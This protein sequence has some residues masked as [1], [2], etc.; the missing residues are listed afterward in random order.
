[1]PESRAGQVIAHFRVVEPIGSGGMGVVYRAVDEE[2]GREVAL[3]LLAPWAM[4]EPRRRKRFLREARAAAAIHHPR[5]ATVFE[6]GE[7]EASGEVYLA[8]ELVEGQSLRARLR[9]GPL[10]L[11]AARDLAVEIGEALSV[12]H[13][14]GIVHRDLKP[15]NVML[16]TSGV[17]VLDFG[18]AKFAEAAPDTADGVPL[19]RE[20]Q[21][22]GT[23]GY[24]SPEQAVGA[25]VDQRADLFALGAM[26]YEMISGIRPF[27]GRSDVEVLTRTLRDDPEPL[28]EVAPG[29]PPVLANLVERCLAKEPAERPSDATVL[30]EQLKA[31]DIESVVV[32]VARGA[33]AHPSTRE[34]AKTRPAA[35]VTPQT[36]PG[37]PEVAPAGATV[38]S[39][40]PVAT[41]EPATV[42]RSPEPEAP[43]GDRKVWRL[44]AAVA[45][46]GAV[47]LVAWRLGASGEDPP[48]EPAMLE[49]AEVIA[50]A[51]E[52]PRELARGIDLLAAAELSAAERALQAAAD[53]APE[54]PARGRVAVYQTMVQFA[55]G[56]YAAAVERVQTA[57]E[58]L[59]ES[60][61]P[62]AELTRY[63]RL[64]FSDPE[65]ADREA[66]AIRAR[67]PKRPLVWTFLAFG[68]PDAR[69]LAAYDKALELAPASPL[70]LLG[71]GGALRQ[72]GRLEEADAVLERGLKANPRSPWLT[73]E[74]GRVAKDDK[75]FLEARRLLNQ[76]LALQP[77]LVEARTALAHLYLE[78]SE[79][80]ARLE[81][82]EVLM[83]PPTPVETRAQF[84]LA[85]ADALFGQLRARDALA[86]VE[87]AVA[88]SQAAGNHGD[89]V[90]LLETAAIR[91]FH[92]GLSNRAGTLVGRY[93]RARLE[94]MP[95]HDRDVATLNGWFLAGLRALHDGQRDQ[96]MAA[97]KAIEA[98]PEPTLRGES[99]AQRTEYL[100]WLAA[101]AELRFEDARAALERWPASPC[102]KRHAE[103]LVHE[104]ANAQAQAVSA[105][106]DVK[107]LCQPTLGGHAAASLDALQRLLAHHRQSQDR[108]GFDDILA[109][110]RFN[111]PSG[112]PDIPALAAARA[113]ED[114]VLRGGFDLRDGGGASD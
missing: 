54:G 10:G 19:T 47:A 88:Q 3:K 33:A 17:K 4:E 28:D 95:Q 9:E 69:S 74:R 27:G 32:G 61:G 108:K 21:V 31:L 73:L 87:R 41:P 18:L 29:T 98:L 97:I 35:A 94:P 70:V 107:K 91:L 101:Y 13:A 22:V 113:I 14:R 77:G 89:V 114:D 11:A 24:M 81:E 39:V 38:S 59:E 110:I 8:M 48:S 85:H 65:A 80:R 36:A 111:W 56:R 68:A 51:P 53:K 103:G 60:Q 104:L 76:A 44:I 40:R 100:R 102:R 37:T 52:D 96:L 79:E 30:T 12:A 58:A 20:G 55:R 82:V 106:E 16:G 109:E 92:L 7:D 2:L 90:R 93:E 26:L 99:R 57:S 45:V 46:V 50:P 63:F 83:A 71:K 105:F 42:S 86:L 72:M 23:P 64:R 112:D 1:M 84:A 15:D 62:E 43:E 25:P 5:V 6:V 34:A 66:E 67:Y 49:A 75:R 78:T